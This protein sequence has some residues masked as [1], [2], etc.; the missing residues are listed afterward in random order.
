MPLKKTITEIHPQRKQVYR[1]FSA[2]FKTVVNLLYA[3]TVIVFIYVVSTFNNK[4]G[5]YK[6]NQVRLERKMEIQ[7]V[8]INKLTNK[9]D[10]VLEKTE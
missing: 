2:N 8:Y 4:I 9:Y 7:T 6:T 1:E 10:N 5:E 3:C